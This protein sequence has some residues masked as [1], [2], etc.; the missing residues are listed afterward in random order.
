[1]TRRERELPDNIDG[2]RRR[3]IAAGSG[4][5]PQDVS[6][7]IKGFMTARS[8]ARKLST[9]S[10]GQRMAMMRGMGD[11]GIPGMT[12]MGSMGDASPGK[13]HRLSPEQKRKLRDK[14]RRGK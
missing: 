12:G 7:L 2:S 13:V 3:R 14:R 10:T 9:M 4:T 8:V 11:G 6:R 5:D 1:M